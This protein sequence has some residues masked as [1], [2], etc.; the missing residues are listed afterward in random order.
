LVKILFLREDICNTMEKQMDWMWPKKNIYPSKLHL[1]K[2]EKDRWGRP[3]TLQLYIQ[4]SE[5]FPPFKKY[6]RKIF[7][8][9]LTYIYTFCICN[10]NPK[11]SRSS[12]F[13][14]KY[15]LMCLNLMCSMKINASRVFFL[16]NVLREKQLVPCEMI[17]K[18]YLKC[19]DPCDSPTW[20]HLHNTK[21]E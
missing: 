19:I 5:I 11:F 15:N 2:K 18:V 21:E 10:L 17:T 9:I 6:F 12:A 8:V 13:W 16:Q 7:G 14:T 20:L 4:I 1:F 3:T